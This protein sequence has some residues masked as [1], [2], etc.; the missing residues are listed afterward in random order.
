MC[1]AECGWRRTAAR[2]PSALDS[3]IGC[4]R[5]CHSDATY[6]NK[7][8]SDT[9]TENKRA[10]EEGRRG[11]EEEDAPI[12]LVILSIVMLNGLLAKKAK[13]QIDLFLDAIRSSY[14]CVF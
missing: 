6:Q 13:K 1:G 11:Q 14:E 12:Y 10:N 9:T 3:L 7:A 4:S 2:I 8:I 5:Y